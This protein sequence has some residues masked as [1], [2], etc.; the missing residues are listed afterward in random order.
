V[1]ASVVAVGTTRGTHASINL[2][3]PEQNRSRGGLNAPGTP[4]SRL[5]RE[6]LLGALVKARLASVGI[7]G[8]ATAALWAAGCSGSSTTSAGS[9]T[10]AAGSGGAGIGSA[11]AGHGGSAAQGPADAAQVVGAADRAAFHA[12]ARRVRPIS[13]AAGQRSAAIARRWIRGRIALRLPERWRRGWV[14]RSRRRSGAAGVGNQILTGCP[15]RRARA[16]TW[17]GLVERA[18]I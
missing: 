10:T 1:S 5:A 11:G 2:R 8:I 18:G 14:G 4:A 17:I 7:L 13:F 12:V 3:I 16:D 9:G 15:V 6:V